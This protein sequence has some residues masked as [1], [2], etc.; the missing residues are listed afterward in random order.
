MSFV[1]FHGLIVKL[2]HAPVTSLYYCK[3]GTPLRLGVKPLKNDSDVDQFVNFAYQNKWQVNLYVEHT[4]YDALDIRDQGET[5]ADDGNETSDAYLSRDEEDLSYLRADSAQFINFV[6][7]P[8]NANDE[9]VVEDTKYI[10]REF[11]VKHGISYI[12][13]DPNQDWKK[14]EPALGMRFDHPKQLKMF[15]ANYD[16]ANGYQLW[17]YKNDWRKLLVYYGRDVEAG[18]CD[19]LGQCKRAKQRSLF[20]YEGGLREHYRRLWEY[21]HANFDLNSGSTCI[22]DD[23]ET[24]SGN[25]YFRRFYVCFKGVKEGYLACCRKVIGLD[26]CFL[27]HTCRGELLVSMARDANNQMYPIAWAVVKIQESVAGHMSNMGEIGFRLG[28]IEDED[29]YKSNAELGIPSAEP[30]TAVTPSADKEKQ[31]AKPSEQPD[32]EPQA[33]KKGSKRKAPTSSEEAP[34]K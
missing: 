21:R 5:M 12:R 16:V 7:E 15:L 6:D 3:V 22:L 17:F 25:Y 26:G 4:G 13:H 28:D 24:E 33:K 32:L 11:N 34:G 27:K 1:Q 9:T 20:D 10:V 29:N 2:V 19:G 31:L 23:K 8:M 18:R 30:I 14:M